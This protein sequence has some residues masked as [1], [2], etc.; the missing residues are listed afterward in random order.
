M[1]ESEGAAAMINWSAFLAACTAILH[2][3]P[4]ALLLGFG[5]PGG[6][7]L[8]GLV[9]GVTHCAGMCGPFVL[10]QVG[11]RLAVLPLDRSSGLQRLLGMALL[12]YHA[13]RA[14]TYAMLGAVAAGLTG[15]MARFF[16]GGAV[17]MIALTVALLLIAGLMAARLD[18]GK[19][20]AGLAAVSARWQRS[21]APLFRAPGG[22]NGYLLGLALG[23]LPCGLVYTALLLAGASGDWLS[24]GVAMAAFSA[25]TTPALFGVG[26]VGAALGARWRNRLQPLLIGVLALNAVI[27]IAMILK[28]L[29]A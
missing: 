18:P 19:L 25:G 26:F 13:G 14:T 2:G 28:R 27:L 24:G 10:S 11:S 6:M 16:A 23:F 20:P 1:T 21:M 12:P 3:Q 9:G 29:T 4:S 7:F 5:L 22:F 8:L 15:G 17:P